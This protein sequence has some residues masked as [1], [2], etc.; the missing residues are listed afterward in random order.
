MGSTD[1]TEPDTSTLGPELVVLNF[2]GLRPGMWTVTITRQSTQADIDWVNE[3]RKIELENVRRTRAPGESQEQLRARQAATAA[4]FDEYLRYAKATQPYVVL[5]ME[6]P[7]MSCC[8]DL[9]LDIELP[10]EPGPAAKADAWPLEPGAGIQELTRESFAEAVKRAS[11]DDLSS[12]D[13]FLPSGVASG[14]ATLYLAELFM[15]THSKVPFSA[16]IVTPYAAVMARAQEAQ[17][18]FREL[19]D[20][21]MDEANKQGVVIFVSAGPRMS[22][23][24]KIEDV[25]I[26]REGKIIRSQ[27]ISLKDVELHNLMGATKES[28]I[29]AFSFPVEVFSGTTPLTVILVGSRA[30]ME[31]TLTPQRLAILK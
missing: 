24:D 16:A 12:Y 28:A 4:K 27:A 6:I 17:R 13:L 25:V 23:A 1:R 26:E 5:E 22:A 15:F 2:D 11:T 29:G 10:R 21:A 18:R 9:S 3:H 7:A 31:W 8:R 14:R 20:T 30:N 19:P